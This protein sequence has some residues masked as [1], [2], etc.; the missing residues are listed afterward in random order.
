MGS[1]M[2]KMIV[3]VSVENVSAA[4]KVIKKAKAQLGLDKGRRVLKKDNTRI[5]F[6]SGIIQK[7]FEN[8]E[9]LAKF[10]DYD[11][12]II[13]VYGEN[14]KA[15]PKIHDIKIYVNNQLGFSVFICAVRPNPADKDVDDA[16][17]NIFDI[18]TANIGL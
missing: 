18:V 2:K 10:K 5:L 9:K 1:Y 7:S 14:V 3:L 12:I 16:V 11:M 8:V 17:E 13:P 15:Y 4:E 6:S